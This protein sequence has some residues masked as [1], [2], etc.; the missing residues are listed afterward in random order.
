ML[1]RWQEPLDSESMQ[2]VDQAER[3]LL[4]M[5]PIDVY[6]ECR[7]SFGCQ[8]SDHPTWLEEG[9]AAGNDISCEYL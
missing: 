7:V 6:P 2:L 3:G 1:K 5:I 8:K 4:G 9:I